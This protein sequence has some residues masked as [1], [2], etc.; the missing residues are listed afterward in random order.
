[1]K[2]INNIYNVLF[3]ITVLLIYFDIMEIIKLPI[4]INYIV[5]IYAALYIWINFV[6]FVFGFFIK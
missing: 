6:I 1:M 2:G 5:L 4:I 3:I